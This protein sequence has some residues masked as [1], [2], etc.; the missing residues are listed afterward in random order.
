[1]TMDEKLDLLLMNQQEMHGDILEMGKDIAELQKGQ[2][3]MRRD[4][5]E[6]QKDQTE[7]GKDIAKMQN[8]ITEIKKDQVEMGKDIT[9]MQNDITE[10]K[11]DQVE[12]G[13]DITQMQNDITEIK[14]DQVEMGRDIAELQKDQA[15]VCRNVFALQETTDKMQ[16]SINGLKMTLENET[17]FNIQLLAEN[18]GNLID[19]LNQAIPAVNRNLVMEVQFTSLRMRI[20]KLEKDV[21]GL[22]KETIPA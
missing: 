22:K 9:K 13:R 8:D 5:A 7:M 6:L 12:M 17:N 10:I 15:E 4:I 18:H 1:M 16:S 3:E 14:K 21:M 2:V 11:K 19:K 20:E